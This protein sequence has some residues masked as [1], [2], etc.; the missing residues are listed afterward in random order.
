MA[1]GRI[2]SDEPIRGSRDL[3]APN[4]AEPIRLHPTANLASYTMG[5]Q[6]SDVYFYVGNRGDYPKLTKLAISDDFIS[7][8]VVTMLTVRIPNRGFNSSNGF[9]VK[10]KNAKGV[11]LIDLFSRLHRESNCPIMTENYGIMWRAEFLG[12]HVCRHYEGL[13]NVVRAGLGASADLYTATGF[14]RTT[15]A[16]MLSYKSLLSVIA[17]S[18]QWNAIVTDDPALGVQMFK[19]LSK[20]YVEAG[21]DEPILGVHAVT[22]LVADAVEPFR[23]RIYLVGIRR[24]LYVYWAREARQTCHRDDFISIPVVTMFKIQVPDIP[25]HPGHGFTPNGFKFK[26]TNSKGVK[27]N[28]LFTALHAELGHEV[29][30][31]QCGFMLR[32]ELIGYTPYYKGLINVVRKGLGCSA[33]LCAGTS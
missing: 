16:K 11:K 25:V 10:V 17:V 27:L 14:A 12:D 28:D 23:V 29:L 20:V 15:I 31:A 3:A 1:N 21:C 18:V 13:S 8:P 9:Q 2:G 32:S 30:T 7:I 22:G 24:G 5:R 4:A 6:A 26:V 33:E 19:K